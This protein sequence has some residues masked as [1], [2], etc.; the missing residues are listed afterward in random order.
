MDYNIHCSALITACTH[1]AF[2]TFVITE[3]LVH[4]S[5]GDVHY[6]ISYVV[7]M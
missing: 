6:I 5:F 7:G 3:R 1:L 4:R 2:R